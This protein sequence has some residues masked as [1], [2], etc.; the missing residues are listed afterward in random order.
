[1]LDGTRTQIVDS[2][3]DALT[4]AGIEED[5]SDD[6]IDDQEYSTHSPNP[7]T[8][9]SPK[10]AKRNRKAVLIV[11]TKWPDGTMA[12]K[13]GYALRNALNIEKDKMTLLQMAPER[14]FRVETDVSETEFR[15]TMKSKNVSYG[16]TILFIE[17]IKI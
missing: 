5:S 15:N 11:V 6:F 8:S 13:F 1:M 3:K 17:L 12:I 10:K 7:Q 4:I 2:K 14:I 9:S 16:G